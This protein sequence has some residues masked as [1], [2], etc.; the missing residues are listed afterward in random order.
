M[1]HCDISRVL[2]IGTGPKGCRF[3]WFVVNEG[4]NA[5]D[6]FELNLN[7]INNNIFGLHNHH[8]KSRS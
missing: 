2:S 6:R 4:L 3:E 1:C 8:C 5:E 7:R